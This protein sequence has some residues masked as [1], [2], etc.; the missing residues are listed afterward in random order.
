[1]FEIRKDLK[2][3]EAEIEAF[4]KEEIITGQVMFYG[5]SHFTRWTKKYQ[6][7]RTMA[8]DLTGNDGSIKVVNHGFG[9]STVED[10]LY[11][12][13]RAVKP[14]KPKAL[15]FSSYLND[16]YYGYS[17]MEVMFLLERL[18]EYARK[19][20]PGIRFYL[21]DMHPTK[22]HMN[23]VNGHYVHFEETIDRLIREYCEK[24]GDC[25]YF[26]FYDYPGFYKDSKD[27]GDRT[28]INGDLFIE[29]GIHY[30][31]AGYDVYT[32]LFKELL[33]DEL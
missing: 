18:L 29:D 17:E 5:S 11:Y 24:H 8:T 32:S 22:K 4:E 10:S 13:D 6:K 7:V 23:E 1:M 31:D 2:E 30:N 16:H 26:H 12:Y 20:M 3:F 25:T 9:G 19:D 21:C 33:K 15:V 14:W 28:R 27:I